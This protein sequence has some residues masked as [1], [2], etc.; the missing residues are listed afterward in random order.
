MELRLN[1]YFALS[2][3]SM[4]REHH[5]WKD[6]IRVA[7]HSAKL[8]TQLNPVM[9]YDGKE[10]EFTCEMRKLNVKIV[11][12]RLSFF[13][14]ISEYGKDKLDYISIASGAFL[15]FDISLIDQVG[16]A[17]YTDCDVIFLKNPDF[18]NA[19]TPIFFSASSEASLDPATNMNS[20]VMLINLS[21]MRADHAALVDFTKEN[22]SLGLDQEI[23][24]VFYKDRYQPMDRSL[25]WKPYWGMHPN[26]QIVHFHG[27][28]PN[29]A[30]KMAQ[31]NNTKNFPF[32][33]GLYLH[34]PEGYKYY[35]NIWQN[36]L[37]DYNAN[38]TNK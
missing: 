37:D 8:N 17:L 35:V 16:F 36:F 33:E 24:R 12:H 21:E 25:N 31:E 19:S 3:A 14:E 1:W 18:F 11:H 26:A 20:G 4:Y 30:R 5:E 15:R 10:N 22:L 23:L 34:C 28:K 7:V 6:M 32:W 38:F 29:V 13:N 9:L 2:E 27:P